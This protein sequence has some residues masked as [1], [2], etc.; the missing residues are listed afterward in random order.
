M[1][2]TE[3]YLNNALEYCKCYINEYKTV[4]ENSYKEILDEVKAKKLTNK[5]FKLYQHKTVTPYCFMYDYGTW[6]FFTLLS[7]PK[8]VVKYNDIIYSKDWA[9]IHIDNYRR[10]VVLKELN[11]RETDIIH[12]VVI[13]GCKFLHRNDELS[14]NAIY[15]ARSQVRM[16]VNNFLHK[17]N[18]IKISWERIFSKSFF[19]VIV[20]VI[21]ILGFLVGFFFQHVER[22]KYAKKIKLLG[23]E[24]ELSDKYFER[25]NNTPAK[26]AGAK[27]SGDSH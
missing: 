27:N 17:R 10:V 4:L 16:E 14:E 5:I 11:I 22:L 12:E 24:I 1:E 20:L 7:S 15:H 3:V 9:N 18:P 25:S 26:E 2:K 6:L 19:A 21:F 23:F 8:C 13:E